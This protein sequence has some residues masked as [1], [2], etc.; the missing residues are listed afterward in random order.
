[1]KYINISNREVYDGEIIDF[2]SE[3]DQRNSVKNLLETGGLWCTKKSKISSV[4]FFIID[5]KKDITVNFIELVSALNMPETFPESF[6]IE[7]SSDGDAWNVLHMEKDLSLDSPSFRIDI[8][9]TSI[10]FL[11]I[12]ITGCNSIEEAYYCQIKSCIAGIAGI[13][14]ISAT[15]FSSGKNK[16][17][18]LFDNNKST[19]WQS[20]LKPSAAQESLTIDLNNAI[21]INRLILSSAKEGFPQVFNI[22]ISTDNNIWTH[23]FQVKDFYAEPD[24]KYCWNFDT[25]AARFIR[26]ECKG[27]LLNNGQ[28]SANISGMNIFAAPIDFFHTHNTG[29]LTPHASIFQPGVVKLAK[30]GE[31]I[32]STVV[33]GSDRRLRDATTIFK[34]IVQIA[35]NG[36]ESEGLVLQSS[37]SRIKPATE[38]K[39]GIVRL[40]H[41]RETAPGTAVQC[42]DSRI[43]HAADNSFGIVKLCPDGLYTEHGVVTGNDSRIQ[44][45]TV[46]SLGICKL[47]KNGDST[48]GSVVQSDDKRLRNASTNFEGIV[49]LAEDGEESPDTAIQ[50][51]DKRLKNASTSSKGIVEL[52]EDGEETPATVVQGNDRRLRDATTS[53]KGIVELA[54]NGED[55]PGVVIQ[56]DDKRLKD[57]TTASKGIVELAEDG[58]NTPGTVIQGN[59]KRLRDATETSKGILSFAR[60]G[61]EKPF[62]A[63]QA[64]DKRLK[65]ATTIS[66]GIM[67][68]AEDGEDRQGVVVQG[69]DKRLK[70]ATTASKGI[71]EMA[72]DGEDRPG[73]VVQGNDKRLKDA[74]TASKGIVEMAENGEDSPG[75]VVQGNDKR[76]KY[77]TTTSKGIVEMAEDGEDLEGVAVQGNDKR[78]K[79]ATTTSKGIVELAENGEDAEGVVVQGNDKRLKPATETTP[80]IITLAKTNETRNGFVIQADDERLFNKREPLPHEHDYAPVEHTFNCHK[81]TISIKESKNETFKEITPPSD[82]SSVI[83]SHNDSDKSGAIGIA[84]IAGI[85][86]EKPSQSYGVVGHSHYVGVRG[87]SSGNSDIKGCGV[88]GISRFGAGGVFSSEHS[89]SLV[90]D[91]YGKISTFDNSVNLRGNGEALDVN[92]KSNFNGQIHISNSMERNSF[93]VNLTEMFEVEETEHISPGDLLIACETGASILSR[94]RKEYNRSVIGIVSGN[95]TVIINNSLKDKKIYPIALAGK[96]FCKIDARNNPVSPG[97]LLVASNTPGCGMKG[98]IDSFDK[99]GT[100]FA[101]ALDRLDDGIGVIPVFITH[102]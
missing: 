26:M 30:D 2:S 80:G 100:V 32:P 3:F 9:L 62:A 53:S 65:N 83:H 49:R 97:D 77:A 1:M 56:G 21:H 101:K 50:G 37:D 5:Y 7:I 43:Q 85:N 59:D 34:G 70:D 75:V 79:E 22:E 41:D 46:E 78:I 66:K 45:A 44:K 42:N 8:P 13:T 55:R 93:P 17:S 76:L 54:K 91:G 10:R 27:V 84:G 36:D 18:S 20:A 81:G 25:T 98:E 51:N 28:Y 86:T 16:P 68:M 6:R 82:N 29:E 48:A 88:L 61:E 96:T 72:E 74:T 31:D 39:Q 71:V 15:S 92:G 64:N 24:T 19:F 47:S 40:G 33:Q 38:L 12:I 14:E 73:V 67:E 57:A 63:V 4:E 35:E 58:E 60:D 52:A 99:I 11:K 87:Q 90:A 69:N 94:S 89:Y 95:P 23:L 102:Q